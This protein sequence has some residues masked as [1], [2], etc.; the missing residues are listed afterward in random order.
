MD[1]ATGT[2]DDVIRLNRLVL[3]E[4]LLITLGVS[5]LY[6]LTRSASL[7]DF[8][9]I[10]HAL[11][12]KKYNLTLH[13]PHPPGTPVYIFIGKVF[14]ACGLSIKDALQLVS[15]IGGGAFVGGLYYF[16]ANMYSREIAW[17]FALILC[18]LPGLW[19]SSAKAMSD[20]LC[21]AFV[22]IGFIYLYL[23]VKCSRK[24]ATYSIVCAIFI[25]LAIGV[26]P[27]MSPVVFP[28]FVY[29]LILHYKTVSIIR[30]LL[31][32][33]V[34]CSIWFFPM[35]ISQA[36]LED[37]SRGL[38]NYFYQ[39]R[40]YGRAAADVASWHLD[41]TDIS[42]R[43][44]F[45]RLMQHLGA[46]FYFGMGFNLWY[47][48]FVNQNLGTMGTS[49][50]PWNTSL[51]EW[52]VSGSLVFVAF[53]TGWYGFIRE[54]SRNNTSWLP[55]PLVLWCLVY[56]VF[57]YI[58]VPPMMRYHIPIFPA[59]VFPAVYGLATFGKGRFYL[60]SV[61]LLLFGSS[62]SLALEQHQEPA[63]SHALLNQLETH[64]QKNYSDKKPLVLFANSNVRRH[65]LWYKPE[66]DVYDEST[67]INKI[68]TLAENSVVYSN[69]DPGVHGAGLDVE[70]LAGFSRSLRIWMRHNNVS[71]YEIRIKE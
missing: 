2:G 4:A 29:L 60:T 48:E 18:A 49:L 14:A 36:M 12:V 16:V 51:K 21:A 39:L 64:Y 61:L 28:L 20:T 62:L 45:K 55:Q 10:N 56:F 22:T 15:A 31:V 50:T 67:E 68:R 26:R 38:L 44:I 30:L 34:A 25:A 7:D 63:P 54:I 58:S 27:A 1:Q 23:S 70:K 71:L 52:T 8:D 37:N 47:P 57:V 40:E 35:I 11:A 3:L 65:A 42:P 33:F 17:W 13:Q 69:I 6:F 53:L 9:A 19:M 43:R 66:I 59:L 5:S 41:F 24:S 46:L 32:F